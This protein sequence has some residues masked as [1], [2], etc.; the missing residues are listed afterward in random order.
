[1][2]GG[3][4]LSIL[5]VLEIKNNHLLREALLYVDRNAPIKVEGDD[6]AEYISS[7]LSHQFPPNKRNPK[8]DFYSAAYAAIENGFICLDEDTNELMLSD[9]TK[10]EIDAMSIMTFS[11]GASK[12]LNTDER[13]RPKLVGGSLCWYTGKML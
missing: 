11:S 7:Q 8:L 10:D 13:E 6:P 12:V 2:K 3:L 9:F 5:D 1:M 4:P